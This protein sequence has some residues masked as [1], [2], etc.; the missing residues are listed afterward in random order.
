M[1]ISKSSIQDVKFAF[2]AGKNML[3]YS[4]QLAGEWIYMVDIETMIEIKSIY[5]KSEENTSLYGIFCKILKL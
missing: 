2:N 4:E 3:S 5:N 1:N